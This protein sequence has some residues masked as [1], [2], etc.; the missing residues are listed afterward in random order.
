[1]S[2]LDELNPRQQLFVME[3]CADLDGLRALKEAGY[4]GNPNG[5]RV[6]LHK[7][8]SNPKIQRAIQEFGGGKL[9]AAEL[10]IE[11]LVRQLSYYCFMDFSEFWDDEGYLCKA[12]RDLPPHIRQCVQSFE[13]ERRIIKSGDDE[14]CIE[15]RIKV[16]VVP[17]IKAQELAMKYLQ[18]IQGG[19]QINIQNN[20]QTNLSFDWEAFSKPGP[21]VIESR[22]NQE[23]G[24]TDVELPD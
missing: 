14:T 3:Y 13:V 11:N 4:K 6:Q 22:I 21:N 5:L 19:T 2:A 15:E 12:P 10:T 20:N 8:R 9:A 16:H 1:M 18:M 23:L 7:L 24:V 17:K